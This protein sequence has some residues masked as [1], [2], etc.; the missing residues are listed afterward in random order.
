MGILASRGVFPSKPFALTQF[1][2]SN[3]AINPL[4][5]PGDPAMIAL[6]AAAQFETNY[7]FLVP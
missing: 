1:L 7:I 6:P 4:G 3:Q 5:Q 2:L